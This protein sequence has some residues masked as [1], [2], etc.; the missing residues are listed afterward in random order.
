MAGRQTD[1]TVDRREFIG[2]NGTLANPAALVGGGAMS[3]MVGAGLDASGAMRTTVDLP[4]GGSIELGR[5][6]C[7]DRALPHNRPRRGPMQ[8]WEW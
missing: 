1:W 4:V 7:H 2:R 8:P 5:R 6:E 3:K